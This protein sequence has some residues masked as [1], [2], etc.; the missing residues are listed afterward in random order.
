MIKQFLREKAV[1]SN[2]IVNTYLRRD[3]RAYDDKAW[4][5]TTFYTDG[6]NDRQ[7][8]GANKHRISAKYHY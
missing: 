2:G 1:I 7:T 4:W 6:I 8:I 3:W 5:D